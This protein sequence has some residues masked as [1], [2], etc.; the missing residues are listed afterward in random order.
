MKCRG[1]FKFKEVVK[2]EAG[3]F[4]NAQ[5]QLINYPES[6]VLKVDE[7][8]ERGIQERVFKLDKDSTLVPELQKI[9]EYTDIVLDF[10]VIFYG[11]VI[12]IVP[13]EIVKK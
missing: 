10:V 11:N 9:E 2:K 13:T 4:T 12:R 7:K 3:S 5:G 8:T 1:I 6:Y